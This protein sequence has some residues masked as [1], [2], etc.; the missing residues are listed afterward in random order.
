MYYL[1]YLLSHFLLILMMRGF[2]ITFHSIHKIQ[3]Y[4][5]GLIYSMEVLQGIKRLSHIDKLRFVESLWKI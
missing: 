3:K 5:D 2:T 4:L 1:V